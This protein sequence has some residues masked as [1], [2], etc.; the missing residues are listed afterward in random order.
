MF[1]IHGDGLKNYFT[2]L[3]YV[4]EPIGPEGILKYHSFAYPFGDYVF[5]TDNTPLFAIPFRWFCHHI[6]NCSAYTITAYNLFI[7]GNIIASGLLLFY[8]FKAVLGKNYW[9]LLLAIVLPWVNIQVPRI[10]AGHFNLSLSSFVLITLVLFLLWFRQ[11]SGATKSA[12]IATLMVVFLFLAFLAHGYYIAILSVFLGGLL[13]TT[14]VI[15]I[16]SKFGRHSLVASV[17]VPAVSL[18]IVLGFLKLVDKYYDL[19]QDIAVGYDHANLKTNFLLLF[20]HYDFHTI[21][22]PI[23][24]TMNTDIETMQYLGNIG[25]FALLAIWVGAVC[26]TTFRL[27]FFAIQRSYFA[28]PLKK[29]IFWGG[30]LSLI[31]SFGQRYS[32]NRDE[33]KIFTPVPWL[34]HLNTNVLL[35]LL[36]S[37]GL[38]VYGIMLITSK[39]PRQ[40]LIEIFKEYKQNP[41]KKIAVLLCAALM[42]FLFIGRYSV[43]I[44]NVVNPFCYIHLI[45][46]RVEQFRCLSRFAWPFFFTFYIWIIYTVIQLYNQYSSKTR[47][48]IAAAALLLGVVE[49][50]DFVIKLNKD[51]HFPN[52]FAT[53]QLAPLQALHIDFQKY[54]AIL[55]FPYY[56]VGSEDYPHTIDDFNDWSRFTMQLSIHSDLPLMACKMSRTPPVFSI[57]LLNMVSKDSLS[58]ELKKELNDKPILI[59][60]SKTLVA[61]PS[62]IDFCASKDRMESREYYARA[63]EFV[64]RHHLSPIDSLGGVMFYSWQPL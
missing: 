30:M 46:K 56:I 58:P 8:I 57:S 3:S 14:G 10:W 47:N 36:I 29:A 24:S 21:G 26:S 25:L 35:V 55:P 9:S 43:T 42:V 27:R 7:I 13:F 40:Q 63:N 15:F 50:A 20:T 54:Q 12:L 64:A 49:V 2:L 31:I 41:L 61:D 48:I 34:N 23:A 33:L 62:Q 18:G 6:Y 32:T 51:A 38:A 22:F 28:D 59:A 11:R 19:R 16:K 60:M 52:E 17:A 37:V 53:Q 5:F 45:T 4:K 39:G 44:I 1:C